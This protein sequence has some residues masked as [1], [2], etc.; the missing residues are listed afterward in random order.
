MLMR[1]SQ[2]ILTERAFGWV[3]MK[4]RRMHISI[5]RA[6]RR[7]ERNSGRNRP[8]SLGRFA[9]RMVSDRNGDLRIGGYGGAK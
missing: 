1:Y 2:N 9:E 7:P 4:D 6:N 5:Q 3:F 8:G